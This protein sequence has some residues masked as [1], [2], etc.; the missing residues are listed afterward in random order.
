MWHSWVRRKVGWENLR[1]RDHLQHIGIVG[2]IILRW[3]FKN[4]GLK[5]GTGFIWLRMWTTADLM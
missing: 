4:I 1:E 3:I 2:G 5:G